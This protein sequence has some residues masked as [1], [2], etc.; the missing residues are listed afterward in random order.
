MNAYD[1]N[2]LDRPSVIPEGGR[3]AVCGAYG[4]TNKHHVI[5]KGMGGRKRIEKRIPLFLVCGMGNL[6]GCHGKF[7]SY[8]LHARWHDGWEVKET[9][10][11]TRRI[12]ALMDGE[13]WKPL[14]GWSHEESR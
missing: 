3:C 6:S 9:P 14:W 7:H 13:G 10:E 8:R 12:D 4:A 11:P 2:M 5:Q 1:E